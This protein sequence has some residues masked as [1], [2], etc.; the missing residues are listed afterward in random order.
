MVDKLPRLDCFSLMQ[1][2]VM[3]SQLEH[4][5]YIVSFSHFLHNDSLMPGLSD[6]TPQWAT[7]TEI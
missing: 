2:A 6:L 7:L 4:C 1:A 3:V 5:D